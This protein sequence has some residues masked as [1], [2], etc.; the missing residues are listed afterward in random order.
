MTRTRASIGAKCTTGLVALILVAGCKTRTVSESAP[1]INDRHLPDVVTDSRVLSPPPTFQGHRFLRGWWPW[2]QKGKL[3]LVPYKEGAWIELANLSSRAR[4]LVLDLEILGETGDFEVEIEI[5]GHGSSNVALSDPLEIPLPS[6]LP[7]G[8]IPIKLTFPKPADPVVISGHLDSAVAPGTVEISKHRVVQEPYSMVDFVRRLD[9]GA[10][11][12]G[13]LTPP[14]QLGENQRFSIRVMREGED[15]TTAFEW[16]QAGWRRLLPQ[17]DFSIPLTSKEGLVRIRLVAEGSGPSGIWTDLELTEVEQAATSTTVELDSDLP[18]PPRLVIL[19]VLDALRGDFVDLADPETSRTP[20]LSRLAQEGVVFTRHQSVAPNTIPSTKSLFTGQIFVTRGHAKMP[21]DGPQT[22]AE[23]FMEAGF[24][25]AAFSGNGYVS[26][27]YGTSRGFE[28][29]ATEVV[30][31]EYVDSSKAYNNN[32]E[33]V[34]KA[35][36]DWLD[37]LETGDRAFLYLH[38][39]HPHNPYDP[40]EAIQ[41]EFVGSNRSTFQAS[42]SNLLHVKHRRMEIDEEDQR[43]I[44][45]LYAGALAY[46]DQQ[47]GLFLDELAERFAREEILLIFTSDHGEELFDHGGVLHGYTLYK[48]Q[49][50]IPLIFSWPGSLSAARNELPTVN[51]DLHETLRALVGAKPSGFGSGRDL[52]PWLLGQSAIENRFDVRFAAA[53]SVKGGIFLAQT[54]RYKLIQAPRVGLTYGM[55][56]GLGRSRDPEY[57]F[58]LIQDPG[59]LHNIAGHDALEV[60]WLRSLLGAWVER[61]KYLELDQEEPVL[62]DK[63]QQQ[64]R[65]LGYLD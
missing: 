7:L 34:Q 19:Y 61:G 38:T 60:A 37:Q 53:S 47:I 10:R 50:D 43:R 11:L 54:E 40:P 39:I 45:G 29:L 18:S 23:S 5:P 36:L 33:R 28:H 49:L 22:L 9:P 41:N 44:E 51:T 24:R 46:N 15:E 30:F 26:E 27:T 12:S 64:L 6:S 20:N 58:D 31:Q 57:L 32:A 55:G 59:E 21:A 65:A 16:P 1:L 48:E 14:A 17:R 25:T 13:E 8:R 2:K 42:T 56:E 62:D 52:W 4:T 63:T 35:A 3:L